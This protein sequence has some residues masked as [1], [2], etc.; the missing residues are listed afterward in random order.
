MAKEKVETK[1]SEMIAAKD[2]II[3]HN[4]YFKEIKV[5]DDLSGV[6]QMFWENLKT[7]GVLVN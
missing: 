2:F 1:K 7:E 6:P 3:A 5:G 4:E